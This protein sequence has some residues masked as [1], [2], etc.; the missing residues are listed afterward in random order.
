MAARL[1]STFCHEI[2]AAVVGAVSGSRLVPGYTEMEKGNGTRSVCNQWHESLSACVYA[3]FAILYE[4]MYV[5]MYVPVCMCVWVV[6][7]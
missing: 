7:L 2:T 6:T 3:I 4:C 5:C 1:S